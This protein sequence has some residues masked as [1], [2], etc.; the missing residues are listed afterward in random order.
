MWRGSFPC[1][2]CAPAYGRPGPES[3]Y[4]GFLNP[5]EDIEPTFHENLPAALW[6]IEMAVAG[7]PLRP[8]VDITG[9]VDGMDLGL[10]SYS[11]GSGEGDGHWDEVADVDGN[12][13]VDGDD[14]AELAFYFGI[15][16]W[17][18]NPW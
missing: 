9:R 6:L 15:T 13:V 10:I 11:F 12:G 16:A 2:D 3:G 8:D 14:L 17:G 4:E 7:L 1:K 18:W 5:P